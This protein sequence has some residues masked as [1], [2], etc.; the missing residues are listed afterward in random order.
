MR[1]VLFVC[2]LAAC[3]A[4][5]ESEPAADAG[6]APDAL[7][8]DGGPPRDW[9]EAVRPRRAVD[10]DPDP[11]VVEVN[12]EARVATVELLPGKPAELWTYD[13]GLPGP[14]IEVNVGDTLK[15]HFTN[16]LPEPTTIHWH[17]IRVPAAMDG[18]ER[19]QTP[20]PPGGTFDY[21]FTVPDAGTYWYH[22]HLRSGVQVG[23]GLYG[24]LVVRDPAE[25]ALGDELVAVI[26]DVLLN[27]DGT[28]A[29]D[30]AG[31]H[32]GDIFGRE[33]QVLLVNGR[34]MPTIEAPVGAALRLRL[35]N[36]ANARYF[37]FRLPG[38]MI[39]VGG[40]GGLLEAPRPIGD[41]VLVPGQRIDL[42][43]VPHGT[44]G[45]ETLIQWLAF[46]RGHWT[47]RREPEDF[48]RVR[49]VEG[50]AAAAAP[51]PERLRDIE[52]L[53]LEGATPQTIQLTEETVDGKLE[54][55]INGQAHHA[56][57]HG[58]VGET[59]IWTVENTTEASHP[60]HLHGFFYQVL[61]EDGR[62]LP[63]WHDT[64]NVPHGETLRLAV[65]FDDRPGEWMFHCHI[66][67][68][69]DIGMMAHLRVTSR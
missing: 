6:P 19:V 61:G 66:L 13:G 56:M 9:A 29:P 53:D 48:F 39:Q 46:D 27:E 21:E 62:A 15:V 26:D 1:V 33:G 12:L 52:P 59:Q 10:L 28:L 65:H 35:V 18:T 37:R 23:R 55:G 67:E 25:P 20:V 16:H 36:A 58:M 38:Q 41:I 49:F 51:L 63:E 4:S 42:V 14:M 60:F 64:V 32:F 40:D 69:A 47:D 31:G 44:P 57:I 17:G 8:P 45:E 24:A 54:M 68:H 2:F 5:P 34:P 7:A 43:W 11:R 3:S 22:P 30:D 50:P